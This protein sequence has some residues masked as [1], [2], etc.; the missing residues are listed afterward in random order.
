MDD[1]IYDALGPL[2]GVRMWRHR[3]GRLF[4][5]SGAEWE[6]V[7]SAATCRGGGNSVPHRVPDVRCT[8]GYYGADPDAFLGSF[9]FF[10]DGGF[11]MGPVKGW[12]RA[13]THTF[14]WRAEYAKPLGFY[15]LTMSPSACVDRP[16]VFPRPGGATL[17]VL[18]PPMRSPLV[19]LAQRYGVPLLLPPPHLDQFAGQPDEGCG[20]PKEPA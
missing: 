7:P 15:D 3:N 19:G 8:C 9:A 6:V 2:E 17:I 4:A 13:I 14:G 5:L 20:C 12:G 10:L 11:V 16:L 1:M 18:R